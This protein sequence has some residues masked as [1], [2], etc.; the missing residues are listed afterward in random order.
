MNIKNKYKYIIL[1]VILILM[2]K[3][4]CEKDERITHFVMKSFGEANEELKTYDL[5]FNY[6]TNVFDQYENA[7]LLNLYEFF[8]N[9]FHPFYLLKYQIYT[10]LFLIP[11]N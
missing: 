1:L 4:E 3:Y 6:T 7:E 10:Y 9:N 5:T 11:I 2:S 8:N